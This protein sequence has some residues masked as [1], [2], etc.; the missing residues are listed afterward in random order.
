[1]HLL[2]VWLYQK[3]YI[4]SKII[5]YISMDTCYGLYLNYFKKFIIPENLIILS[6][7]HNHNELYNL[8][9]LKYFEN[10]GFQPNDNGK[11]ININ[12]NFYYSRSLVE[13][14]EI[15]NNID[16]N[17]LK[18]LNINLN[19]LYKIELNFSSEDNKINNEFYNKVIE[20]VG[21][22]YI[23][24]F[25]DYARYNSVF[26]FKYYNNIFNPNNY[27]VIY[28]NENYKCNY[29]DNFY[30]I[31]EIL[32]DYKQLCYYHDIISN[33]YE[34]HFSNSFPVCYFNYIFEILHP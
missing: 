18:I 20:K 33:T 12:N 7:D 15:E 34:V 9:Y 21:R 17:K 16:I 24:I 29:H 1:M 4:Y 2:N 14:T 11:L 30:Y 19:D 31:K 13:F 5:L 22:N 6:N 23:C 28:F 32:G 27:P 8:E 25:D 10:L 26:S 3:K